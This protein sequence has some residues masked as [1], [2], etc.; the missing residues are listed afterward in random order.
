MFPLRVPSALTATW[1][2]CSPQVSPSTSAL[3]LDP[4]YRELEEGERVRH[5]LGL[6]VATSAEA[7]EGMGKWRDKA[8]PAFWGFGTLLHQEVRSLCQ[9]ESLRPAGW[10]AS[11]LP[12]YSC[13]SVVMNPILNMFK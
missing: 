2:V 4:S 9:G 12:F 10:A 6:V 1:A 7:G 5:L 3:N 13:P 8:E 11:M